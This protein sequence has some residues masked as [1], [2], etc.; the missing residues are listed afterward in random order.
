MKKVFDISRKKIMPN[1]PLAN[2][3]FAKRQIIKRQKYAKNHFANMIFVPFFGAFLVLNMFLLN[4]CKDEHSQNLESSELDKNSYLG[5][6]HI[7]RDTKE[8]SP[9]GKYM[10]LIFGANGCKYCERLKN[11]IKQDSELQRI[12]GE[13]FS[14]YYINLSYAKIHNFIISNT[15][16]KMDSKTESKTASN[17]TQHGIKEVKLPTKKLAQIYGISPTPTIVLASKEGQSILQYPSYLPPAQFRALLGFI[18][19]GKWSEAKGDEKKLS[20]LVQKELQN[21]FERDNEDTQ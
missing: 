18:T 12:I 11:D 1:I 10:L 13:E 19:S 20:M 15:E 14:A 9:N 16:S 2:K 7:F 21:A 17:T 4:G 6:E 3:S 5:L 8:I